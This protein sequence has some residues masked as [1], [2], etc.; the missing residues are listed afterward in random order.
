VAL[1]NRRQIWI[2]RRDLGRALDDTTQC[3]QI[4]RELGLGTTYFMGSYNLGE[5]YYQTGDV[6]AAWPHVLR[7]VELERK[8]GSGIG[9]PVARLLQARLLAFEES[10]DTARI[11]VDEIYSY[12]ARI[13]AQGTTEGLLLPSEDVLLTMVALSTRDN[14]TDA[15]WTELRQRAE[16]VSVEQELIEVFEMEALWLRRRGRLPEARARL[17]EAQRLADRIPNLMEAR[18]QKGLAAIAPAEAQGPPACRTA[19]AG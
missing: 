18:L 14:T 12:Q 7:A 1:L 10:Q 3:I 11:W 6:K 4:A 8:R 17:A 5:M 16:K 2:A 9:R 15:E 19:R 13:A